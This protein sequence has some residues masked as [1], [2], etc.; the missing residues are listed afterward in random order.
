MQGSLPQMLRCSR[1]SAVIT[2]GYVPREGEGSGWACASTS[3]SICNF[4]KYQPSGCLSSSA[5]ALLNITKH[6]FC[7]FGGQCIWFSSLSF[8]SSMLLRL[9]S[10]FAVFT[11]GAFLIA[12]PSPKPLNNACASPWATLSFRVAVEVPVTLPASAAHHVDLTPLQYICR[13]RC[14][15]QSKFFVWSHSTTL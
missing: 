2:R 3:E 12:H 11:A 10:D 14:M 4:F 15:K 1:R 5:A 9:L 13:P 8:L 6:N 7:V